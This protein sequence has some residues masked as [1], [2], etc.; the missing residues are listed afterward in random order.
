MMKI[1]IFMNVNTHTDVNNISH[2]LRFTLIPRDASFIY[3]VLEKEKRR[4]K[5]LRKRKCVW[6]TIEAQLESS[7]YHHMCEMQQHG[8]NHHH[9]FL[10]R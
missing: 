5:D 6:C 2:H 7:I 4:G 1:W 8:A 9:A 3:G 10:S